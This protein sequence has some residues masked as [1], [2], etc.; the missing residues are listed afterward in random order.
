MM[1]R[2][3][4]ASLM[5]LCLL[6]VIPY[7]SQAQQIYAC[8]SRS[9]GTLRIVPSLTS[10]KKNEATLSW[11]KEG[12]A[13]PPGDS[14]QP[15]NYTVNCDYGDTVTA[16]LAKAAL[17]PGPVEIVINGMCREAVMLLRSNTSLVAGKPGSGLNPGYGVALQVEGAQGVRVYSLTLTGAD[18]GMW[19][20][21]ASQVTL[22]SS[23][24]LANSGPGIYVED[25][26]L[27]L[28]AGNILDSNGRGI[29]MSSSNLRVDGSA[30][31]NNRGDGL[32]MLHGSFASIHATRI[33]GNTQD[34]INLY[35]SSTLSVATDSVLEGN[36]IGIAAMGGSNMVLSDMVVIQNNRS[37]GIHLAD[38]SVA[39]AF[40]SPLI[41]NNGGYG[42]SCSAAPAVAQLATPEFGTV[43]DNTLGNIN[44]PK[45]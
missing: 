18:A 32:T 44:C 8:Y 11:N 28:R 40:G 15:Q 13:G 26:T 10:C 38:V 9:D 29:M 36:T 42:V 5:I 21:G 14:V 33:A 3:F 12:P 35:F 4:A 23:S 17:Y 45:P 39:A 43:I 6:A 25:S 20:T 22:Y 16:A 37:D 27:S 2:L 19:I 7:P 30:I 34:G 1:N 41:Q 31:T 24:I